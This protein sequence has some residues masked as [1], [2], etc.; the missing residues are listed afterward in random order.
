MAAPPALALVDLP[1]APLVVPEDEPLP[2]R[3]GTPLPKVGGELEAVGGLLGSEGTAALGPALL[4]VPAVLVVD[5]VTTVV[6]V[7][8][9]VLPAPP[10]I[11]PGGPSGRTHTTPRSEQ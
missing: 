2:L 3:V 9:D 5:G 1:A 7:D 11:R 6:A 10:T 8:S 4:L